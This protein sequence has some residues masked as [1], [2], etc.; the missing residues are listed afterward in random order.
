L[1]SLERG[2]FRAAQESDVGKMVEP[3]VEARCP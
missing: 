3:L 1:K 2:S